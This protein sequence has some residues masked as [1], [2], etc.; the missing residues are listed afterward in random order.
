L[1]HN[2]QTRG[3]E[4]LAQR[5]LNIASLL[6][7]TLQKLRFVMLKRFTGWCHFT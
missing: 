3:S 4:Y 7:N 5:V 1:Q 2:S 6:Q